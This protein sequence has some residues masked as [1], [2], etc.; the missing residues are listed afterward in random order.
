MKVKVY[1]DSKY[2]GK[3]ELDPNLV[4]KCQNVMFECTMREHRLNLFVV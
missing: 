2:V 1:D 4:N 3:H